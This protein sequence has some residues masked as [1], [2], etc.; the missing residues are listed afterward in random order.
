[1]NSAQLAAL[2]RQEFFDGEPAWRFFVQPALMLATALLLWLL[3]RTWLDARY[4]RNWWKPP[5]PLW[6]EL[7]QKT[8]VFGAGLKKSLSA[9]PTQMAL[10]APAPERVI[11]AQT[12]AKPKVPPAPKP[13]PIQSAAAPIQQ[14]RPT[15]PVTTPQKPKQTFWDESKGVE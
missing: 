13:A 2:L 9:Q 4:E 3:I 12:V 14:V 6:R 10:P 5:V 15:A 8:L 7:G 1:V 11:V